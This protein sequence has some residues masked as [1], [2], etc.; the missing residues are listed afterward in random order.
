VAC[1][2]K[3]GII[4][5][6]FSMFALQRVIISERTLNSRPLSSVTVT[7]SKAS[8]IAKPCDSLQLGFCF[9]NLSLDVCHHYRLPIVRCA[10]PVPPAT[11]LDP[12]MIVDPG[13]LARHPGVE[14]GGLSRS[15]LSTQSMQ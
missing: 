14:L 9:P 11:I 7:D 12:A 5:L 10:Q 4:S 2:S 13:K 6:Y 1:L 8:H 3:A 15:G